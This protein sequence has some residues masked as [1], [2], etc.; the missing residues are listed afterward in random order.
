MKTI[1]SH[2]ISPTTLEGIKNATSKTL[3]FMYKATYIILLPFVFSFL[4]IFYVWFVTSH[5]APIF[6]A[7]MT[8]ST[9]FFGA[10]APVKLNA[11]GEVLSK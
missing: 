5:V 3:N 9:Y 10:K 11:P 8:A 7:V 1:K 2:N 6:Y 4:S